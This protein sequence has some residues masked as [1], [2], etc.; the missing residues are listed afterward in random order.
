MQYK[1]RLMITT[2]QPIHLPAVLI[3]VPEQYRS[4][5]IEQIFPSTVSYVYSS[6]C[7]ASSSIP[8]SDA[9]QYLVLE[10]DISKIRDTSNGIHTPQA[11]QEHPEQEPA[12]E[13]DEQ[14]L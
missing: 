9:H 14:E 13:Q 1:E 2:L 6:P 12:Q 3:R 8:Q 5:F 10:S 7:H 4:L 11:V